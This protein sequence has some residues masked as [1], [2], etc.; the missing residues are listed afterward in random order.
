MR[1]I[2][3]VPTALIMLLMGSLFAFLL[4]KAG[5]VNL[6]GLTIEWFGIVILAVNAGLAHFSEEPAANS[7][8]FALAFVALGGAAMAG[9]AI[10]MAIGLLICIYLAAMSEKEDRD[11]ILGGLKGI[12]IYELV[13]L[14]GKITIGRE[15]ISSVLQA[16]IPT[17][18]ADILIFALLFPLVSTALQRVTGKTAI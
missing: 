8:G 3:G 4:W 13:R 17:I 6:T 7:A 16:Y 9:H 15:A 5:A 1:K 11:M 2:G 18:A 10:I 14:G 12:A